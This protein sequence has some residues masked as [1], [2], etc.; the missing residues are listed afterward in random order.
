MTYDITFHLSSCISNTKFS[1]IMPSDPVIYIF[2]FLTPAA[3]VRFHSIFPAGVFISFYRQLVY[4]RPNR[5]LHPSLSLIRYNIDVCGVPA[6]KCFENYIVCSHIFSVDSECV[7]EL[8]V[9]SHLTG[10]EC[11]TIFLKLIK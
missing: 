6:K 7:G 10:L 4:L 8:L 3:Y 11:D 2:L 5:C 9:Q 1:Q